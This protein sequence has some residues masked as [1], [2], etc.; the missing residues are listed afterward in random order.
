MKNTSPII[1]ELR[2]QIQA[3]PLSKAGKRMG[4]SPELRGSIVLAHSSSGL[5][6]CSKITWSIGQ[7]SQMAPSLNLLLHKEKKPVASWEAEQ[8]SISMYL[9]KVSQA[10]SWS[11]CQRTSTD[12]PLTQCKR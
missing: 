6:Q 5:R 7:S 4:I 3:L 2:A 10:S 8:K 9:S 11:N 1:S 12:Q